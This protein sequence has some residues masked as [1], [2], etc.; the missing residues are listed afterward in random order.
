MACVYYFPRGKVTLNCDKEIQ[1][2]EYYGYGLADA[3]KAV[4]DTPH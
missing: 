2:P 4:I 1:N 3:C